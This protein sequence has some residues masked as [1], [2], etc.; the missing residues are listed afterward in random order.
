MVVASVVASEVSSV[1]VP[2]VILVV[3]V[4]V[5]DVASMKEVVMF[6]SAIC[7]VD[8]LLLVVVTLLIVTFSVV[9][10][11]LVFSRHTVYFLAR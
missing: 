5:G 9:L 7:V 6:C 8:S 3:S 4:F 1:R 2:L 11:I 10:E